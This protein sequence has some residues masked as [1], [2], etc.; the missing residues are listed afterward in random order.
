MSPG[1]REPR[2]W[3]IAWSP[4]PTAFVPALRAFVAARA[5]A[6]RTTP[7]ARATACRVQPY[8]LKMFLTLSRRGSLSSS[9]SLSLT[10]WS[11]SA[12]AWLPS[13]YLL[14]LWC[15]RLHVQREVHFRHQQPFGS[16]LWLSESLR[17]LPPFAGFQLL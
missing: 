16:F 6:L 8:F 5:R 10:S 12:T 17:S 13:E 7:T 11:L 1:R 4:R 9:C 3:P 15:E 2:F 14:Q